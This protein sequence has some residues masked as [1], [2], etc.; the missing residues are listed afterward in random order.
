MAATTVTTAHAARTHL[1]REAGR[2]KPRDWVGIGLW[3][4]LLLSALAWAMPFIFMFLTS[5]KSKADINALSTWDLP[6]TFLWA[7]YADAIDTGNL[8]E[9]GAN[10][11]LIALVKVPLGLL[12]A[13]GAAFALARLRFRHHKVVLGL[14]V[15]GSMVPI[16]VALGPLFNTMLRLD[17]LDSRAG[18]ILPYLAFGIPYQVF[19][20]YGFFKAIPDELDESARIDGAST[21][22]VFWQICLPLARPALAALFILDFVATWNEYAMATTLL[23]SQ[24][25]WTIPLAVQSFSS[26]HATD[27][28]SLNAFIIMSA[29]PVLIVYLMFQRYFVQG[30]FAGAVKG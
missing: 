28:G 29:V 2:R 3:I 10:S 18:L 15:V 7:N 8:W 9:T 21:F 16:Q 20:L 4:A 30:A 22:R 25:N 23:Q 6:T 19:M 12:L 13:S 26:Q 17:L 14:F 1:G 11:L 27:Y 24:S 5:V